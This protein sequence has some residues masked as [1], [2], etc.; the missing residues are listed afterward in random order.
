[1]EDTNEREVAEPLGVIET[2]PHDEQVGYLKADVVG[3]HILDAPVR[4]F[5][6]N[7][8]PDVPWFELLDLRD[9]AFQRFAC[10]ENIIDEK[11]VSTADVQA[12]F[13]RE[14]EFSGLGPRAVAGTADKIEAQRQGQVTDQVG[15]EHDRTIED[16]DDDQFAAGEIALD[17]ARKVAHTLSESG[18]GNEDPLD[19]GAPLQRHPEGALCWGF[20]AHQTGLEL[21]WLAH[22]TVLVFPWEKHFGGCGKAQAETGPEGRGSNQLSVKRSARPEIKRNH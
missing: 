21:E 5:E 9:N 10:I 6:E 19:L 7:A 22:A 14:D 8:G 15:D 4:L 20:R 2:V 11:H 18:T 13:L 16:C 12:Q 17:F 3:L 1:V